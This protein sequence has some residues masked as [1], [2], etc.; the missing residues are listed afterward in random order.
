MQVCPK[1]KMLIFDHVIHIC[2]TPKEAEPD[3]GNC[4][5]CGVE[6]NDCNVAY[7]VAWDL[8][9]KCVTKGAE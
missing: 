8:C 3:Y 4:R 1:C 2:P 6:L 9:R 7:W 5:G